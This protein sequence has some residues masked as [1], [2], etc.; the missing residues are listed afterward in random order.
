MHWRERLRAATTNPLPGSAADQ[1][2]LVALLIVAATMRMWDLPQL[3][4]MHDEISALLRLHPTLRGTIQHGVIELDTHPPGVQIFE[5]AWTRLFGMSEPLVKL[6]FMCMSVASILL[7]YRFAGAWIG[8]TTA[9]IAAAFMATLQ[10]FVL[11][12]QIARPYAFG[13]FTTALLADQLTRTI[14]H[15][16]T[17]NLAGSALAALLCMY[18]HHF[19]LMQAVLMGG[20]GLLCVEPTLRKRYMI[21]MGLVL[22]LYLPNVPILMHQFAQGG[23]GGWLQPPDRH[24]IGDYGWWIVHCSPVLAAVALA[25][26]A[27]SLHDRIRIPRARGP[28]MLLLLAWGVVP[29]IAGFAYS[30]WRAPVLQ[31]STLLFSFPFVLLLV[32]SGI[33]DLPWRATAMV[34]ALIASVS[35]YTLVT[36]RQHY[37]LLYR[38]KYEA[39][40]RGGMEA[41]REHGD[42]ALVLLDA[43]DE[44]IRFYLDHWGIDPSKFPYVQVRDAAGMSVLRQLANDTVHDRVFVGASSGAQAEDMVRAAIRFPRLV[45]RKDH[46]EGQTVLLARAPDDRLGDATVVS[47]A[48]PG[49]IGPGWRIS[50]EL[51]V[52]L[53]TT[54]QLH[55][56]DHAGREFG[57]EFNGRTDTLLANSMDQVVIVARVRCTDPNRVHLIAE[58]GREDRTVFYRGDD[59]APGEGLLVVAVSPADAAQRE[60][61]LALKAYLWNERR[62]PLQV[63]DVRIAIRPGDPVQHALYGPLRGPWRYR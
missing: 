19:A 49:S 14:A 40:V 35:G 58:L 25:L 39:F 37:A 16:R 8:A 62:T 18:A 38:S 61:P 24:W 34:C 21:A 28:I 4:Y 20:T 46:F 1:G 3:P 60:H 48:R 10:Y 51:P 5:W 54:S 23:L 33:R 32:L 31:Y 53:D 41:L 26:V 47:T 55:L 30:V 50:A 9:L 15:G 13:L 56:W 17:A 22:L 63:L 42:R 12:G 36:V 7:F 52:V 2:I 44:M 59:L 29:L 27:W 57:I 11:Y 45:E 6:P 43:P